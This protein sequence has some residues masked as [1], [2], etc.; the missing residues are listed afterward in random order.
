MGMY[1][2]VLKCSIS[3]HYST[4]LVVA[5]VFRESVL[6]LFVLIWVSANPD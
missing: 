4:D 2:C 1:S 3:V 5:T 6:L